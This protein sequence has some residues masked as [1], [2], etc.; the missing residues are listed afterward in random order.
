MAIT[1]SPTRSLPESPI[2]TGS[3]GFVV[4]IF[5]SAISVF[6]SRP[7]TSASNSSSSDKITLISSAFSMTWLFVRIYPCSSMINPEPRLFWGN[8]FGGTSPK[9]R[10][11]NSSPKKSRNGLFGPKGAPNPLPGCLINL[12]DL[13]LITEGF[14]LL[15]KSVK[16]PGRSASILLPS[17]FPLNDSRAPRSLSLRIARKANPMPMAMRMRNNLPLRRISPFTIFLLC[18]RRVLGLSEGI[19]WRD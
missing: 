13:I 9:N 5:I 19:A 12:V 11:K 15:A 8:S 6:G 2:L 4:S 18:V 10:S 14:S 1:H 3:R 17:C 7:T 16:E